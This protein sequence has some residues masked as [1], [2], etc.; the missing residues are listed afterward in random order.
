MYNAASFFFRVTFSQYGKD[1][2]LA[3][4]PVALLIPGDNTPPF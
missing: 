1:F 4:T 3:T 2:G